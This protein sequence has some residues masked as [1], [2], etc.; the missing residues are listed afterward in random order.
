MPLIETTLA[1]GSSIGVML[2]FSLWSEDQNAVMSS[3]TL[4]I[5]VIVVLPVMLV[6][7]LISTTLV[8]ESSTRF[9]DDVSIV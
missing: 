4:K 5:P 3:V 1:R 8:A 9:P 2:S 7:A 6:A